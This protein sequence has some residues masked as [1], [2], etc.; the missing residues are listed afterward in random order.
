[1]RIV[2]VGHGGREAALAW[3]IA[4]SP[5]LTTLT[6]TG[7]NSGWPEV[8]EL[9]LASG[10]EAIGALAQELKAD[11]VIA[12]PEAPLAEGLADHLEALGIPCFGPK[13]EAARLESSKAFAKEVMN[14]AGIPTAG[15]VIATRGDEASIAAARERCERGD[16]VIKADGLAAGKGVIVCRTAKEAHAALDEMLGERFGAAAD[17]LVLED[18]LVGPEVSVFAICDG[19]RAVSLP[20]SQDHKTLLNGGY[21]PNTGGMG[22]YVPCPLVDRELA[23]KLVATVH[24]PVI[25]ELVKRGHPFRGVLYGGLMMTPDGPKVLEFNVRFGDP[26]C[27][28]LMSLW[29]DDILPWL[30]GA[31][32]GALPE[33]EPVFSD[34]SAC[35]V[36]LASAGY[37]V[38][39]EKGR[40]IP[41]GEA[42]AGVQVFHAGTRRDEDGVLRTNGGRCLGIT[43]VGD[44][45]RQARDRAYMA[46][47]GWTFEG[48][49]YRTDIAHQALD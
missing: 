31:A 30:H 7:E 3:R 46:L 12:G 6:V 14:A 13:K 33:G 24:Q 15:A 17:T 2:L 42:V 36:V 29:E 38:S 21:G 34:R 32:K 11:L 22:A 4:Q 18:R 41:E 39:S 19:E 28:P 25:D 27:Q 23:R 1:M 49:Q 37:P 5:S 43:G 10:N 47:P 20:S 48:A 8:A 40:E 44:S 35:C 26:E 45:I 9:R 16:V